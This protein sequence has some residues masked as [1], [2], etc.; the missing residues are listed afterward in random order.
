[1]SDNPH[2]MTR[3]ELIV[4]VLRLRVGIEDMMRANAEALD[5]AGDTHTSHAVLAAEVAGLNAINADLLDACEEVLAHAAV[6][7]PAEVLRLV[8]KAV[9]KARGGK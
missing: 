5:L 3:D 7:Q 9:S 1:M 4:E 2:T 6:E 8:S